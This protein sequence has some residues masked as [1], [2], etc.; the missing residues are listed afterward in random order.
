MENSEREDVPF[1]ASMADHARAIGDKCFKEEQFVAAVHCYEV[2]TLL[3]PS[4]HAVSKF[5]CGIITS[6]PSE[7][8]RFLPGPS[9]PFREQL[10]SGHCN[11]ALACLKLRR[12]GDAI[13]DARVFCWVSGSSFFPSF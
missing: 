10:A 13:S 8:A 12:Y 2:A 1:A 4:G 3:C 7:F 9:S 6:G 11:C 5:C